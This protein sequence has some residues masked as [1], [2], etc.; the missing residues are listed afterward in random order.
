M[1]NEWLNLRSVV[2]FIDAAFP[3]KTLNICELV[4]VDGVAFVQGKAVEFF[5]GSQGLLWGLIFYESIATT[6]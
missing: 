1:F 2:G 4:D 3:P 5:A 6:N